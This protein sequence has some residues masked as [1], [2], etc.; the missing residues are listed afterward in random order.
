[1]SRLWGVTPNGTNLR[2][3]EMKLKWLKHHFNNISNHV[4]DQLHTHAFILRLS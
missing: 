4:H 1:M 2:G 3:S